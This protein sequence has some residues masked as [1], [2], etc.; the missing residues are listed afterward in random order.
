MENRKGPRGNCYHIILGNKELTFLSNREATR[1]ALVSQGEVRC[2][3]PLFAPGIQKCGGEKG[4]GQSGAGI[5]LKE[6]GGK[7]IKC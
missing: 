6:W 4:G 3:R 7:R 5:P 2:E 1:E